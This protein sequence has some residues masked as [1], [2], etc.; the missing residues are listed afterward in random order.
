MQNTKSNVYNMVFVPKGTVGRPSW[1]VFVY[2]DWN[3]WF[4]FSLQS[5]SWLRRSFGITLIN[6]FHTLRILKSY[7]RQVVIIVLLL[8]VVSWISFLIPPDIVPGRMA[9]LITLFLVLINIFNNVTTNSPKVTLPYSL[10]LS[11]SLLLSSVCRHCH[12]HCQRSILYSSPSSI[13][14]SP[15]LGR[16]TRD[17]W[18]DKMLLTSILMFRQKGWQ[19]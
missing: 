3:I 6:F 1:V 8:Q 9:L 10:S 2:I 13:L 4:H 19:P 16:S 15:T 14:S 5:R 18:S 12:R 11:L 17:T 7:L